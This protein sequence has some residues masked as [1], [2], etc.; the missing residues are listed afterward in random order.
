MPAVPR[1][2]PARN[3]AADL[4]L[5]ADAVRLRRGFEEGRRIHGELGIAFDAYAAR[6]ISIARARLA[7]SGAPATDAG[8]AEVLE[9]TVLEDLYLAVAC[10]TGIPAAWEALQRDLPAR[11]EALALKRGASAA[12]AEEVTQDVIGDLL[13]PSSRS[14][15]RTHLG[16]FEGAGTLFS[17]VAGIALRKLFARR[18]TRPSVPFHG[19]GEPGA[20]EPAAG[21]ERAPDPAEL[22]IDRD[23]A[24]RTLAA[25]Q[26]AWTRL[27]PRE[28]LAVVLKFR[29]GLPQTGIA[30]ILDVGEPR[31]TRLIQGAVEKIREVFR[32]A[33]FRGIGNGGAQFWS[34]LRS[35][36]ENHLASS[37]TAPP[38]PAGGALRG[39]ESED[40]EV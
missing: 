16:S 15:F 35:A 9:R 20:P 29:D 34:S 26:E 10:D 40:G 7:R 37:G 14:A 21:P 38:Q 25:L 3:P 6:V 18:K 17:W 4:D 27:T 24:E 39:R 2:E 30:R 32:K 23:E 12:E 13:T 1:P 22:T 36:L 33:P 31:V 19:A 28:S 8:M 5:R 11:L